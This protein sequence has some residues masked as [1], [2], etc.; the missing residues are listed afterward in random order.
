MDLQRALDAWNRKLGE[1]S[2]KRAIS[3]SSDEKFSLDEQ[4]TECMEKIKEISP[5][6]NSEDDGLISSPDFR[7]DRQK[8]LGKIIVWLDDKIEK[9]KPTIFSLNLSGYLLF[10]TKEPSELMEFLEYHTPDA[11]L[12]DYKFT[13]FTG[14]N[15]LINDQESLIQSKIAFVTAYP[16]EFRESLPERFSNIPVF[17]KNAQMN[18]IENREQSLLFFVDNLVFVR[19]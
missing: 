6:V 12:I 2:Y 9:Y 3:S 11:V 4:I 7:V 1:L 10:P 17:V 16:S 13:T 14:L 18:N 5:L 15:V 19:K 8:R